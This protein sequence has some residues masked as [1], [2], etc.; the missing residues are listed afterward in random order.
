VKRRIKAKQ[1]A[2]QQQAYDEANED[3]L[4]DSYVTKEEDEITAKAKKNNIKLELFKQVLQKTQQNKPNLIQQG[5]NT[6]YNISTI[7]GK[8]FSSL[9]CPEK[10]RVRF[11]NETSECTFNSQDKPIVLMTMDTGADGHYISEN[12]RQKLQLPILHQS[13]K[14]VG[15]ADGKVVSGKY[16]T[17][18]PLPRFSSTATAADTFN[19]WPSSLISVGK[20]ADDDTVSIF[21]KD[22]VSVF[23]EED[24]LI[25]CK[26]IPLLVGARDERGRYRVPLVQQR[27][28]WQPRKPSKKAQRALE[29]ANSVYDLPSTEQA[30]KWMHAV[31]GYP[32]KSTWLKAIKA[33]NFIGWPMLTEKNVNKYYPETVETPKGHLNQSRKNVRSTK[34]KPLEEYAN[35]HKLEGKKEKDVYIKV[36]DAKETIYSDQT[37]AFPTRSRSGNKYIMVMVDID[38]N[39]ILVEPMKS[40]KDAEMIRAYNALML[41]LTR[42]GIMPAKHV[43]DNEVS[44]NMKEHIRDKYKLKLELVPPGCHRRNA[45]EVAIRNFK[46]HFLSVL[47]GVAE[48]FPPS[49]WDKLLPQTEITLNLL[50]QSNATP[51]VSAYAHLS[52]PFDYNKMPLAPMGCK[53]QIHEKSNQRGTWSYHTIDGWYIR[54]SPE[55]YRTH[56]CT[57]KDTKSE[58]LTDTV[59]LQHKH[60]TNPTLTHADKLMKALADS[61]KVLKGKGITTSQQMKDLETIIKDTQHQVKSNP[62]SMNNNAHGTISTQVP[63]VEDQPARSRMESVPRV[64]PMV[65]NSDNIRITRSMSS[66]NSSSNTA[67]PSINNVINNNSNIQSAIVKESVPTSSVNK[68]S[69]K[70]KLARVRKLRKLA[71]IVASNTTINNE[72]PASRTRAK[73]AEQQE[74]AAPPAANTRAQTKAKSRESKIPKPTPRYL[75]STKNSRLRSQQGTASLANN[76]NK[77]KTLL[78]LNKRISKLENEVHQALAVMDEDTGKMLNYRSLLKI[79]K[80]RKIWS[81]SASNEFGRLANGVGGRIKNPTNTIKFICEQDIPK[82]R[83]KDVTYGQ[84]VCTVRPEKEEKERSR[85]VA[86]GDQTNFPGEVAT[87][88]ADMLVAKILMN[89][90]VSTKGARFMT[91]DISNFYLNTPMSRPEYIRIRISDIPDEII[92]EYNLKE[93]VTTNGSIYIQVNKGMYGLPQAGLMANELLEKRL[94]KKGYYQSKLVPG[95]WKHKTRPIAFALTVDDFAVKYVGKEHALHLKS[96]LE[97]HYKITTDWTGT[98]YIG[99]TLDWDYEKRQVHVSMP[100]YVQKALKQFGHVWNGKKQHAPFPSAPIKYGAKKQYAT[101]ESTAPELDKQGKKFIQQ[102][103]GKFLYLGRAVDSTLLCPISAIASQSS[104]PTEDTMK[105][106]KQLLDYLASQEEAVITYNSSDMVL[107]V[108]SDASYL[109]EPKARSRAGGHFFLSN[110][111]NIP[112]NNGAILNI[113]HIIKHVMTSATEAELAALYIMAREAVY[114]RIILEELGHKQ[115]PTPLQ[116]DNAM[117]DAVVNGKIQPKRTKAMDMRLHWLRDRECQQQFRIYWRPGK[118]NYADYWTKHHAAKHHKNIRSEYLTPHIVVEMLRMKQKQAAAAA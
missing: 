47:A 44:E 65:T 85:F 68:K 118:L 57:T 41:R 15:V 76:I 108:H 2:K 27:G 5:R 110:N 107:G 50:R 13:K 81:R 111:S 72:G 32:V 91:M 87:P 114:I 104:K 49:L 96:V 86:G 55:H 29:K 56:I 26:G 64:N 23:K 69:N 46:S 62:Q 95:L 6:T 48:D 43:L 45:A 105:Q 37:G 115:P 24:V 99:M 39:A 78:K 59:Q 58:R 97:Q 80:F 53:A 22:G 18:L 8:A 4:I 61:I 21:N 25:K 89:S 60:I 19:P 77:R 102:V 63:R 84:M 90:V 74:L 93:K 33:G 112:T 31:C 94:N 83:K 11:A 34:A 66:I 75:K 40:R 92:K 9:L 117:A 67:R 10:R 103:C 109:S 52:G 16:K 36:Y 82:N 88:T 1:L 116:T 106:A 7:V 51:T 113:A 28:Q 100:G 30:I 3:A 79:P 14:R 70:A 101:E 20:L 71:K 35:K 73:V 12:D 38:S 17:K 98:R 54:T 42:A